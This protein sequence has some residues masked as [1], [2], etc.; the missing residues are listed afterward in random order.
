ML[1]LCGPYQLPQNECRQ[2]NAFLGRWA[3]KAGIGTELNN[4]DP[5]GHFLIDLTADHPAMPY[6]RDVPIPA[7]PDLR[8]VNAIELART[9][10]GFMTR[11]QKGEP[12]PALQL[13]FDCVGIA[14]VDS[15]R[16]MLRF[17]GLA[18]HRHFSRR[19]R[20]QPLSLCVGLSAIHFFASG[21]TPFTQPHAVL[22]VSEQGTP[23]PTRADLE[24]EA[25]D[26]RE[27]PPSSPEMFRIDTRWQLRDE[28]AGGLSLVR[29]GD[30]VPHLRVGDILGIHN[31]QLEQWRIGVVRWLK[32]PDSQQLEMGVE[33]LAP[34]AHPVAMR[35]A[36]GAG[37]PYAPALLLPGIEVLRQ[38]A[39]LLVTR[40]S[41]QR[42]EDIDILDATLPP[43]R[44]R[45]LSIVERTGAFSQVVFADVA[46]G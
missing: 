5:V 43:R 27:A 9:V 46:R 1:G 34:S 15:L 12:A 2:V 11:L 18:G 33:M 3:H 22:S 45:V 25:S 23:P 32:S 40:G 8:A 44:V 19:S 13:G 35:P 7:S 29:H 6:P 28:S 38:P 41:C 21:Q 10:H 14:C 17:W 16:R 30:L 4:V 20:K 42:G 31:P 37:V 26:T 36:A 24:A 39:T